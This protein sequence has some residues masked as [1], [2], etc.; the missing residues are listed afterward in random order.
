LAARDRDAVPGAGAVHVRVPA[1]RVPALDGTAGTDPLALRA[2]RRRAVRGT[3][4]DPG[5]GPWAPAP[6]APGCPADHRRLGHRA[7]LPAALAVARPGQDLARPV[8]WRGDA[9][10][11]RRLPGLCG[12]P[13]RCRR[14]A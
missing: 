3:A 14:A 7:V 1:D 6:V 2:G 4:A 5:R 11:L 13:A 8:L 9:A 12:V 10:R